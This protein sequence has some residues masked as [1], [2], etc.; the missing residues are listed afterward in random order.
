[1]IKESEEPGIE[2]TNELE[3]YYNPGNVE[4]FHQVHTIPDDWYIA[5]KKVLWPKLKLDQV[6]KLN[7]YL[8][9]N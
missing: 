7:N 5:F 2:D 9:R 1:M 4:F 6:T 8:D 3:Y